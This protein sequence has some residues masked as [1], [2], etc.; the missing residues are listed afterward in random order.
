MLCVLTSYVSRDARPL[1]PEPKE[2]RQT[3]WYHGDIF[4]KRQRL[5][6]Q[7]RV[8]RKGG[9]LQPCLGATEA[10]RIAKEAGL[11]GDSPRGCLCRASPAVAASRGSQIAD[12]RCQ[13]RLG[14]CA[15]RAIFE[16]EGLRRQKAPEGPFRN[17]GCH[18]S[19]G[20]SPMCPWG[21]ALCK[22]SQDSPDPGYS[23]NFWKGT[24]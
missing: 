12:Q 8:C 24:C 13:G 3:I 10:H 20:Q 4:G 15:G 19:F 22:A 9:T 14:S 7:L 11:Q 1:L 17:A 23:A 6:I 16:A 18:S 21:S 2:V 5:G